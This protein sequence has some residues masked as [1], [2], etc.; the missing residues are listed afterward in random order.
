[1]ISTAGSEESSLISSAIQVVA[2]AALFSQ[3]QAF[4]F[5]FSPNAWGTPRTWNHGNPQQRLAQSQLVQ[6][7]SGLSRTGPRLRVMTTALPFSTDAASASP[8]PTQDQAVLSKDGNAWQEYKTCLTDLLSEK[9]VLKKCPTEEAEQIQNFLLDPT[10]PLSKH[11]I[12][13]ARC[14]QQETDECAIENQV[15]IQAAADNFQSQLQQ[16]RASFHQTMNIT[17]AQKDY[18]E[19]CFCYLGDLCAKERKSAPLEVAWQKWRLTGYLPRENSI[20]T[21]MYVLGLDKDG[22]ASDSFWDVVMVHDLLF[23]P[24]EKTITLRIQMLISQNNPKAAEELIHSLSSLRAADTCD[25]LS[26]LRTFNPILS[27]YCETDNMASA[28]RLLKQMRESPGVILDSETYAMLLSS[29][30]SRGYFTSNKHIEGQQSVGPKLFDELLS[31]MAQDV[32]ELT[33]DAAKSLYL[34]VISGPDDRTQ[35][36]SSINGTESFLIPPCKALEDAPAIAGRVS[37]NKTT[38]VCT[39]TG[40][41][42]RLLSLDDQQREHVHETLAEM[43][44]VSQEE[45]KAKAQVKENPKRNKSQEPPSGEYCRQQILNFSQWISEHGEDEPFTA[46]VDGAN[47]AFFGNGMVQYSQVKLM[48][49]KLEQMGE[50]PLVIMPRK[51]ASR[52]FHLRLRGMVQVLDETSE[53]A[54]ND[55][56]ESGKLFVVPS[57]CFDDYYWMIASVANQRGISRTSS[58][59]Q[60][61]TNE[62]RQRLS[63]LRPI[64]ITNDQMRD[65]RLALLDPRPFRRWT[66]CHIVNYHVEACDDHEKWNPERRVSLFPP[67]TFSREIQ[68]NKIPAAS[69]RNVWHFPVTGWDEPDRLCVSLCL[70][71]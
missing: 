46:F 8:F 70:K 42:L 17:S 13:N 33:E 64:L 47:V 45:F 43:A 29:L 9:R 5:P 28:L 19:R 62:E 22:D 52:K 36:T 67:S 15:Y 16:R 18:L 68:C 49:D 58:S 65:H 24:N 63:G 53:N 30:A 37:I 4:N 57:F 14:F 20:S 32:L 60:M 7:L 55:L 35:T 69:D 2:F 66:S 6:E 25:S 11:E 10:W 56:L 54:M 21:Y 39:Q 27:H 1:M 41:K 38:S 61:D 51:Y 59:L 48:V 44:F 31:L 50:R 71:N 34:G 3:A 23:P 26:K 12:L 40:A